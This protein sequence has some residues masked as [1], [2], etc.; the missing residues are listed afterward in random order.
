MITCIRSTSTRSTTASARTTSTTAGARSTPTGMAARWTA[1]SA[2][3]SAVDG[4]ANGPLTM[5]YYTRAD[6][7]FYYALADA[8]T[9]CDH[10]SC[11]VIGPTDPNRLYTMSASLDPAGVAGG[12]ILSTSST[13]V[14]RFGTLSWTTMPEQ[15]QA[16]GISW[17]VYG[18]PDGNYGDNVLPYF[19]QYQ[20]NPT[21]AANGL[22]PTYPGQFQADV[23]GRHLAAGLV[24]TG[25]ADLERAPARTDRIRRGR[26]RER[27]ELACLESRGVVEDGVVRHLRR[28]RWL[29]RSRAADG[30]ACRDRR[31]IP[32]RQSSALGRVRGR[33]PDRARA[34]ASRC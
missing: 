32:D 4:G 33:R 3:I 1:S 9:I 17:K 8:F 28:E 24:G 19:K 22:T 15:L 12:P 13:R 30:R 2:V 16:R 20:T 21:L 25:A 6:L 5:G 18:N 14:E 34:S 31:R 7:S 11:S 26:D 10:Y 23:R 27:A 29:L